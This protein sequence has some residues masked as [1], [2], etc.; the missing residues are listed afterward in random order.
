MEK[1]REVDLKKSATVN[2]LKN[3]RFMRRA[4][5]CTNGIYLLVFFKQKLHY[6]DAQTGMR[7]EKISLETE[8]EVVLFDNQ[9]HIF[10]SIE[11]ESKK[12]HTFTMPSFRKLSSLG[13]SEFSRTLADR[14]G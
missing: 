4:V 6:F 7:L 3:T 13:Q 12:L 2:F 9:N 8:N 11:R 1:V 14:V 10:W 5:F